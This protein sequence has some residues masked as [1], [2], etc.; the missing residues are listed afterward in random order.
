MMQCITI[1]FIVCVIFSI[2][3][4]P[5]HMFLFSLF[6]SHSRQ[7]ADL[8]VIL[9]LLL[10]PNGDQ[11]RPLFRPFFFFSSL[12]SI[13]HWSDRWIE[14]R[15]IRVKRHRH[16]LILTKYLQ[17]NS[18]YKLL[19]QF[20][21]QLRR[22]SHTHA[23][24]HTDGIARSCWPHRMRTRWWW[25]MTFFLSSFSHSSAMYRVVSKFKS[26]PIVYTFVHLYILWL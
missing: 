23:H 4:C 16:R 14:K 18:I 20:Y 9:L 10:L 21:F 11:R 25:L 12:Q 8:L 2:L 1:Y 17:F 7:P 5:V 26:S 15:A 13:S 22:S 6:P 19:I 3:S 24:A